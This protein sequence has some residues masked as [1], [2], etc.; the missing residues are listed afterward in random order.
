MDLSS[1]NDIFF[2]ALSGM[3]SEHWEYAAK[4]RTVPGPP[5]LRAGLFLRVG[6]AEA[7]TPK[8]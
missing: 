5:Q 3:I 4:I 7:W 1:L 8:L 6:G 2:T